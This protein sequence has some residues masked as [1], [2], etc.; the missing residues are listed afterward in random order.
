MTTVSWLVP[1]LIEGSGGHRTILQNAEFLQS[2]HYDTTIYLEN[3]SS[4]RARESASDC[5]F[6]LFG[7]RFANVRIGWHEIKPCDMVFATIWYSAKIVRDLNFACKKLY[8]VQ[9]WEACFNP[10]GDTYL[11]AENSY[12]YGLTPITIGNWLRHEIYSRFNTNSFSFDFFADTSIYRPLANVRK[13]LAICF[14]CQ[15]EKPRRGAFLGIEAL[16]IVKHLMPEVKIYLYGS[17]TPMHVWFEHENLGL[18]NLEECNALYNRCM[19]GFCISSSNPSRIPFEMMAAGL[20]IIELYRTNTRYDLPNEASILCDQA[21]ESFAEGLIYLLKNAQLREEMSRSANLFMANKPLAWGMKQVLEAVK[22]VDANPA[23]LYP[24]T[25]PTK[26]LYSQPPMS[27]A[28]FVKMLPK[29]FS[30]KNKTFLTRH[31]KKNFLHHVVA[32]T[33]NM[34]G[35]A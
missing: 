7:Y 24:P 22:W 25:L 17:K 27:A 20:P 19:V 11:L 4:L 32:K 30:A 3:D 8:F 14:I 12:R 26:P 6:R 16:G 35:I 18:I 1:T 28:H 29:N 34:M 2:N 15:P 5:I 23:G 9:D 13:E 31:K 21:P 10:M 33:K